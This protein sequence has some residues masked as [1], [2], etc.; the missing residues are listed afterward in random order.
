MKA[1]ENRACLGLDIGFGDVKLVIGFNPGNGSTR[2]TILRKFPTAI[3]YARDGIIGDL[4][5]DEKRYEFNGRN[6]FVGS[7][8]LQCRDVFSTRDIDFL[9]DH[10]PLLAFAAVE[11][12]LLA[13][14]VNV[15]PPEINLSKIELCLGMPI[16]HFHS[17]RARLTGIMKKSRVSD[18]PLCFDSV[19]VRAQGQ[20]IF[21]D[22]V[23][24]VAGQ[25]VADHLSMNVLVVDIG[26][27]TVDILGVLDG[28][29][30]REWSGMLERGG[31]C[32]IAEEVGVYLQREFNFDLSEQA[33]KDVIRKKEIALYGAV[34]DI[35]WVIRNASEKYAD[36]LIQE[37]RSRWDGFLKT[38]DHLILAGGGAYYV[39]DVFH[40]VYPQGFLHVPEKPEYSNA[41][42][43]QKY[44]E[45]DHD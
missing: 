27:N 38:A 40:S 20:G 1:E 36:W 39:A 43:F 44:L 18:A 16:A 24:D 13:N 11:K 32:R 3:S 33:L 4:G 15:D 22:F 26:F 37:I 12:I 34:K 9:I 10:S 6:Y 5:M 30:S 23:F 8:A 19:D 28:R 21:F 31:I 14:P 41:K 45:A 35:S 25:P 7:Q 29:P 2:Q 17:K 42:G